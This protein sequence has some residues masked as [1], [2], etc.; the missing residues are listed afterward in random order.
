MIGSSMVAMVAK[1]AGA[2]IS[3]TGLVGTPNSSFDWETTPDSAVAGWFFRSDGSVD[4]YAFGTLLQW[5]G[6]GPN[7]E[8]HDPNGA[9]AST[10]YIRATLVSGDA[11]TAGSSAVGSILALTSNRQW[12]WTRSSLGSYTGKLLIEIFSDAGGTD[13]LASGYYQGSATIE[14]DF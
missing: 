7:T 13:L 5:T 3:L 2:I 10:Y 14:T 11:P 12:I 8:W 6:L 9:P 4:Y 1:P